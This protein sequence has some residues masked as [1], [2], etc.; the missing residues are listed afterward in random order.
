MVPADEAGLFPDA[1]DTSLDDLPEE[2][3]FEEDPL[4]ELEEEAPKI[5]YDWQGTFGNSMDALTSARE[6]AVEIMELF[7]TQIEQNYN[8]PESMIDVCKVSLEAIL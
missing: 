3:R 7:D 1:P 5:I 2:A 6:T 8:A 4:E